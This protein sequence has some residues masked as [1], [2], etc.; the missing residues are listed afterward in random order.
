MRAGINPRNSGQPYSCQI[1]TDRS[2]SSQ[3]DDLI[4]GIGHIRKRIKD[5]IYMYHDEWR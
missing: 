2:I 3:T 5:I 4:E 1:E